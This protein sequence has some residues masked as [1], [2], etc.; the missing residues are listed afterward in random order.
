MKNKFYYHKKNPK[1]SDMELDE[2]GYPIWKDSK[3]LVHRT[4]VEKH[5]LRGKL[6]QNEIVH[7]VD[8]DKLNYNTDNL[9]VLSRQDHEKIERTRWEFANLIIAYWLIMFIAYF[10]SMAYMRTHNIVYFSIV[11]FLILIALFVLPLTP[12]LL[13]KILFKSRILEKNKP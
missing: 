3:K 4:Q 6:N 13:R 5:I 8:G 1:Y 9:V 12:K 10:L 11:M 7:H 2:K